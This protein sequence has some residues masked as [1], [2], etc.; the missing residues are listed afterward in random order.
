MLNRY[1][2]ANTVPFDIFILDWNTAQWLN[3]GFEF[4]KPH[5]ITPSLVN[6]DKL[7]NLFK[8]QFIYPFK[9]VYSGK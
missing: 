1:L 9:K 6:M 3:E 4:I 2:H 7:Y 5:F 8:I